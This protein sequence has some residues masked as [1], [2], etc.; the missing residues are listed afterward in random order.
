MAGPR[1]R[2]CLPVLTALALLW[3]LVSGLV[4]AGSAA[5]PA[6]Q[7]VLM[8]DSDLAGR[9]FRIL[10]EVDLELCRSACLAEPACLAFT[11]NAKA[12]W[13][14][15]KDRFDAPRTFV[16]A[17]SGRVV[18]GDASVRAQRI[19]E[20]SF[21]PAE[22]LASAA[23]LVQGLSGLAARDVDV[24]EV[25]R[26]LKDAAGFRVQGDGERAVALS[27]AVVQLAP[28]D[29]AVWE[30]LAESAL[31]AKPQD[32]QVR[33]QRKAQA[34]AAAVNAYLAARSEPERARSLALLGRT[35]AAREQWRPA[36]L[37]LRASLSL[38][39]DTAVRGQ[40]VEW[41]ERHGFRIASHRIDADSAS[42]RI[43]LEFSH[44]LDR[45]RRNLTDFVRVEEGGGLS[46]EAE[47][48][49]ICIDGVSHGTTYRVQV[50]EGLPAADGEVLER[51]V[52]LELRVGDRTPAAR[53]QGRAYVLPK[54][55]DAAIPVIS[56]NADRLALVLYR[57]GERS[58][59]QVL[60]EGGFLKTLAPYQAE[61]IRDS[62]GAV[63]R[64]PGGPGGA[65]SGADH[66]RAGGRA[67]A[68]AQTRGLCPDRGAPAHPDTQRGI[69]RRS[70]LRRGLRPGPSHPVVRGLRPGSHGAPG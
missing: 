50:R 22:T 15:L 25:G 67:G 56:V 43:C 54:G 36:I 59:A 2:P 18:E 27:A 52:D 13:C 63:A 5:S 12:R 17:I 65:Q 37:A 70:G 64:Q 21:L 57:I 38:R 45:T 51:T 11:Y 39:E 6:R 35:L 32:W 48:R 23:K 49:Q 46:V 53:F 40:Y 34:T 55:G 30:G 44:P 3:A 9:D 66:G 69:W 16:G 60:G 10:K 47:E 28:E 58:I 7:L 41:R 24:T 42:P 33:E 26:A 31:G 20:L 14:F 19:A 1:S 68:C 8:Q 4:L 61:R 62:S 29:S